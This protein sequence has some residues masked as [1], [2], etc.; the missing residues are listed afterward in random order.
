MV[1]HHLS[2]SMS[3]KKE[4]GDFQTPEGL[5]TRVV[6]LVDDFF[7][8][9][10]LVVEPTAGLGAFLK[11]SL[12]C[13]GQEAAYEGYE[14]NQEYVDSAKKGLSSLGV[15]IFLADF[16]TEDWI[17]NLNKSGKNRVLVIGNPPWVTNSAPKTFSFSTFHRCYLHFQADPFEVPMSCQGQRTLSLP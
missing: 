4:F 2:L 3:A 14:I 17:E 7:G 1:I 8:T 16:F 9:P 10:D 15:E 5:A 11:A 6:A 12:D 13:W